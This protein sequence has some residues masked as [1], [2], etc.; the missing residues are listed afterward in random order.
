MDVVD[1]REFYAS[2]LGRSACR[3]IAARL[4]A[5]S[6][7]RPGATIL[8]VGFPT[9]YLALPEDETGHTLVFMLAR[10]GVLRWPTEGPAATALVDEFDLPLLES[11][12]DVAVAIHALE[13]SDSP[14]DMLGELWRVLAPQGRLLLVVPHRRGLWARADSTPFGHGQPYSRGQLGALLKSCQFSPV[15]WNQALFMPPFARSLVVR[16]A[17]AWERIGSWLWSAFPGVII[18]EAVKQVYAVPTAAK[19]VRR[20]M[21]RLQ[22]ALKP[23]AALP[24]AFGP[25][26]PYDKAKCEAEGEG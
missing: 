26:A 12:V 5:R 2:P 15:G 7:P 25:R 22:P 6:A 10:Q 18:V 19:R 16:S 11:M 21:P 9:P 3:L 23:Q 13:L 8:G 24:F 17:P 1:L 20:L 4:Q 14:A